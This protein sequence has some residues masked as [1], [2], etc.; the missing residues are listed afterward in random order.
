MARKRKE[1]KSGDATPGAGSVNPDSIEWSKKT[2]YNK[3]FAPVKIEY[4]YDIGDY[5]TATIS[6][7]GQQV[8]YFGDNVI[9]EVRLSLPAKR[10]CLVEE[11]R[12]GKRVKMF[13]EEL[14]EC[15]GVNEDTV[16]S[17]S[18]TFNAP[19]WKQAFADAENYL[20]AEMKKL[21]S[22]MSKRKKALENAEH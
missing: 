2:T 4:I 19:T 9:A 7:K 14:Y 11:L 10:G 3:Y 1:T 12:F 5:I 13:D 17:K 15:W 16:R 22:E 18:K 21:I 6:R 20:L 8:P